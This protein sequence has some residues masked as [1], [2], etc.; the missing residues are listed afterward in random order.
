MTVRGGVTAVPGVCTTFPCALGSFAP[1]ETRA[2]TSSVTIPPDY[3]GPVTFVI[4]QGV[5][6]QSFDPALANNIAAVTTTI[7]DVGDVAD[8]SI[9]KTGPATAVPGGRVTYAVTVANA[10]P[11]VATG[12]R[13]DDPTPPGLTW[14]SSSGDCTTA[15]PC[16][17][18][19]MASGTT[20]TIAAT[21]TVAGG[22][23]APPEITNTATVLG[24]VGDPNPANNQATMSTRIRIR[25]GCDVDGDG[26]DEV[27]TGAGPGGGPHVLVWSLAGGVVT[28][29]ASF[30]AY[31]PLFGGGVFVACGDLD[32][33]GLA[34]V[35]TGA[36]PGGSPHVRA[37]SLAGGGIQEIASFN[38]YD[39]LFGGGVSVAVADVNGDGMADVV[40]GAG[41][42]GGPHVRAF[43]LAGGSVTE[44]AS[45]YAYDPSFT[46]GVLVAGGD[47]NG[48]GIAEITT[49]TTRAGGPVRVFTIGGPAGVAELTSFFAYFP[50]FEGPVRVAAADVNGD[51]LADIITGAGPGGGPH[52]VV[53]DL[54]GGGGLTILASFYAYDPAFC[55]IG[56]TTP[57]PTLC[58]GVYVGAGDANGDGLAEVITG[59]N[60][61]GGPVRVFQIGA[62][63]TELTSFYPYFEAFRG[64]VRTAAVDLNRIV[65]VVLP[66]F[67]SRL[68]PAILEPRDEAGVQQ[69]TVVADVVRKALH[70]GGRADDLILPREE[71]VVG[72]VAR[73]GWLQ[74]TDQARR[75]RAPPYAAT[76]IIAS[77]VI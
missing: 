37:F 70:G 24:G 23:G 26:L 57:D 68:T 21:Y 32:G 3:T 47:V 69:E 59:T 64:P 35:V 58:D 75:A 6:T 66:G 18:G 31:D 14:V 5:N 60:R 63:V 53:W 48:D 19:T 65:P 7:G 44:V 50:A 54:V 42:G 11:A 52:V 2:V 67:L 51:G 27:V 17:L 34:D 56:T 62:S 29:L 45:F 43:S 25:T 77:F 10:G 39:P 49:G 71:V 40:T 13:V 76:A 15:F 30:Y 61:F 28:P 36:G 1:G 33:D 72:A 74:P 55:D 20:R 73:A 41:P 12:V 8:L 4:M 38:A 22:A 16:D 9:T 46:G